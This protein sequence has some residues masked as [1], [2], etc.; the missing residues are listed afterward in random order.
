MRLLQADVDAI[1]V[2]I[3]APEVAQATTRARSR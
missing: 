2:R 1:Y 3:S